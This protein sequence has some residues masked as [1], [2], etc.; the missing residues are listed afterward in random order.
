VSVPDRLRAPPQDGAVLAVPGLEEVEGLL[1][2]N[3]KLLADGPALCGQPLSELRSR[4]RAAAVDAARTYLEAA[5][6]PVPAVEAGSLLMAGHQPDLFHPGVWV[7]NFALCGLACRHGA[8][9]LNLVVDND[10]VKATALHV[11]V[12]RIPLPP[13]TESRPHRVTVPF[14][15]WAQEAPYEERPVRDEGLFARLPA[16]ARQDWGYEPLLDEFWTEVLRQARRT[17]LLGE[18]LAAARRTFE[19][20][21]G[22][23][24]LEVPV[25]ALCGTEPFAW[26]AC[27]LLAHLPA[28]HGLHNR[29]VHD[30]RT[31]HGLRSPRHPVPDLAAAGGWLEAPFWAWRSGEGRRGRLFVRRTDDTLALRAGDEPWPALPL[32]AGGDYGPAV[33][34]WRDLERHGFKVRSRALT[35]TL[36]ARVF[37]ADLFV[38]G[39]GGG[40]YDQLTDELIRRFYGLEPPGFLVLS[41]TLLLPLPH[42]PATAA[43]CRALARQVRDVRW[44]PQRH[45]D[46]AAAP[47]GRAQHLA[48]EK[49]AWVERP[50]AGRR[51]RRERFRTLRRLTADLAAYLTGRARDLE[52]ERRRCGLELEANRVLAR[53]DYAFCLYPEAQLRP[54]CVQ[55][56]QP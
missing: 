40:K 33:R 6:E 44:N 18:R 29:V 24:N 39:I 26:F 13:V 5:G 4:A 1:A 45:L 52:Q 43:E 36:Y 32:P 22:C 56:L 28:F 37:L 15:R 55:F 3:R 25:S 34:A 11:P 49:G 35:N 9:A 41:A 14:D 47:D 16:R 10:T 38:H 23:H 48:Q 46:A 53:R 42:Y 50:A 31:R 30:Y 27:H 54:F 19:R 12:A 21:W 17:P 51:E 20:R 7:K 8:T 2:V